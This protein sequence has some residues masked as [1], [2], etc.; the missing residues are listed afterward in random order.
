MQF[1]I[2][3]KALTTIIDQLPDFVDEIGIVWKK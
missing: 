1:Y 2:H 3:Q